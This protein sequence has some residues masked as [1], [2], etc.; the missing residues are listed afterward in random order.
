MQHGTC[1]YCGKEFTFFKSQT[2]GSYCSRVCKHKGMI[3]RVKKSCL[4]CSKLCEIKA[5]RS[6]TFKFCSKKCQGSKRRGQPYP[7]EWREKL[8]ASLKGVKKSAAHVEKMKTFLRTRRGPLSNNWR[9][10]LTAKNRL[11]R[12]RVEYRKWREAVFRRDNWM[13]VWCRARN[14]LGKTIKLNADHIKPFALYPDLRLDVDNGRTLCVPCHRKTD[15]Y[16]GRIRTY[17]KNTKGVGC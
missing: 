8:S 15:T 1:K 16:C 7:S 12:S 14:G 13:C 5:A 6:S 9:G 3:R 2:T 11:E 4:V 10:G 17:E